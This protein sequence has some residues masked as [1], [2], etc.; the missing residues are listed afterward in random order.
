[1]RLF[2]KDNII[3]ALLLIGATVIISLCFPR[4]DRFEYSYDLGK[5]W[6]YSLLTAPFDIPIELDTA[7]MR[8]KRDSIDRV[9]MDIYKFEPEISKAQ[10]QSFSAHLDSV[11]CPTV[12]K[13]RIYNHLAKVYRNGIV[14]NSTYEKIRTGELPH[15][16][17]IADNS[18]YQRS[19]SDMR[20]VK[21][22]YSSFDSIP[23]ISSRLLHDVGFAD[24]LSPNVSIDEDMTIKLREAEYQKA[25]T[26]IGL[27]QKGERIVDRGEVISMQTFTILNTYEQMAR[28]RDN[29]TVSHHY[30]MAGKILVV[31]ILFVSIYL[32]LWMIRWKFFYDLRKMAFLM[33]LLTGFTVIA[34]LTARHTTNGLYIVPFAMIPILITTFFDSRVAT[35]A[36]IHEVLMVALVATFPIEFVFVQ[37]IA[38]VTAI[39]SIRELSKRAQLMRAAIFVFISYC[40]SFFAFELMKEGDIASQNMRMYIFFLINAVLLSFS[41]ILIFV[42]EKLFGFISTVTLVEL[43][44]VNN[45]LLRELSQ[46]CPGTFQHSLQVSNL[47]AEAARKIHANVQL[48]RVGALYHDVGKLS[49]PAF[50]TENQHGVNPHTSLTPSQSAEIVINHVR[51][52]IK[53]AD[54][55]KLPQLVADFISQHHGK[56]KAK[57]FYT[58]ACNAAGGED[59][60]NPSLFSYPGPNPTTKEASILMMADAVEAASRSLKEYNDDNIRA[61][62]NKIIDSQIADGMFADSPISFRD[63]EK[64]KEVF[65]ERLKTIYHT[66]ISYPELKK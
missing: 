36:H 6:P 5:P 23:G 61:L 24:Y 12:T 3:R 49:N 42:I 4:N 43:A 44:D 34:L 20:S 41:Y 35:Y 15:M 50:F 17:L 9:F 64:V 57:Y 48:I 52:G 27:L 60:V 8:I 2:T 22:A 39:F 63:V 59:K 62:V 47:C 25:L 14:D 7:S 26:P 65:I 45:P 33:T 1:M 51:D 55:A 10:L 56:G 11:A 58:M 46:E 29:N 28:E 18:T 21:S 40:I 16:R 53:L 38:G 30:P 32:F 54:K 13:N 31:I 37:F 66:R 19:T